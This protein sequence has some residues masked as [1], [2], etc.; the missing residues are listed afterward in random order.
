MLDSNRIKP[1]SIPA[2]IREAE[3][4]VLECQRMV[5][6]CADTLLE[7]VQQ[8]LT[9]PSSLLLAGGIGFILSEL[10][11]KKPTESYTATEK[12][13]TVET[14]DITG[15]LITTLNLLTS[16]KAM[17]TTFNAAMRKA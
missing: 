16:I 5:I 6:T 1:K 2:Q 7:N 9:A 12:P 15:Y 17:Y 14:A 8:Q 13:M 10:N 4:E 11:T 3:L